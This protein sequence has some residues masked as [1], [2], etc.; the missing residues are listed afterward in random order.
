MKLPVCF[1]DRVDWVGC[2]GRFEQV[3]NITMTRKYRNVSPL[4]LSQL[5]KPCTVADLLAFSITAEQRS[6]VSC[7]LLKQHVNKYVQLC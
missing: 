1:L 2:V 4:R 5:H 6:A 7:E 3:V